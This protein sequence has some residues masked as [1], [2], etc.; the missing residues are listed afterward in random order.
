M[1]A[2][3]GE[4]QATSPPEYLERRITAE[5]EENIINFYKRN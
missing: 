3:R 5:K 1:G 4:N 2:V